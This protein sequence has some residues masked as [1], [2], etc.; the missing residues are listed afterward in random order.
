MDE[1]SD[2]KDQKLDKEQL[3]QR[4]ETRKPC[5]RAKLTRFK[6]RS[7]VILILS[8]VYNRLNSDQA[9]ELICTCDETQTDVNAILKKER[10]YL[11]GEVALLVTLRPDSKHMLRCSFLPFIRETRTCSTRIC[12]SSAP[13]HASRSI[14]RTPICRSHTLYRCIC[15]QN[16][17]QDFE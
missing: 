9:G 6:Y 11:L 10:V 7:C 16:S 14:S 12:P 13:P 4:V 3:Q 15:K 1:K 2:G 5:L 17:Q 8:L